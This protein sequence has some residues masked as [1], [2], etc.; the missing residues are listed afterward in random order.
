MNVW[1]GTDWG[2]PVCQVT[3]QVDVPIGRP[4]LWCEELIAPDDS[5]WGQCAHGPWMH[6]E[7]F[8]R[9]VLGSVGHQLGL[10]A[11]FGG[12]YEGEP[13][14]MSTRDAARAAWTLA[15][16]RSKADP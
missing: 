5:G 2:A 10:C 3:P 7:C 1:F 16:E 13:E 12:D 4:C 14:T 11:C 15:Q 9:Q 6:V 8:T